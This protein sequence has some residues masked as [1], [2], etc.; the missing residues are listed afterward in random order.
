MNR[1][2]LLFIVLLAVATRIAPHPPNFTPIFS[3]ALFSGICF[4]NKFSFLVP[5]SIMIISDIYIGNFQMAFWVYPSLLLIYFIGKLFIKKLNYL[6]V[7]TASVISSIL[8]FVIT[9]FGVWNVGYPK[10]IEGFMLCYLAAIP[11]FKNTL[12]ASIFYSSI[13][14]FI[15]DF[16]LKGNLIRKKK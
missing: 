9:N 13:L 12:M 11:F 7:F 1:I 15:Y 2:F 16:V 8:F 10:T 4:R 14:Y 3:I 6:N 5:L